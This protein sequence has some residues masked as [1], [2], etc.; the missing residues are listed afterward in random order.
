MTIETSLKPFRSLDAGNLRFTR[1]VAKRARGDFRFVN[2]FPFVAN[3]AG[4][5]ISFN[6]DYLAVDVIPESAGK[7][8]VGQNPDIDMKRLFRRLVECRN[9]SKQYKLGEYVTVRLG[10]V[11]CHPVDETTSHIGVEVLDADPLIRDRYELTRLIREVGGQSMGLPE[12]DHFYLDIAAYD[13]AHP[14]GIDAVVDYAS[15]HAP[16]VTDLF[17]VQMMHPGIRSELARRTA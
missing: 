6:Q 14:E 13:T 1:R 5:N 4:A 15:Q 3:P 10:D 16:Q 17:D 11:I 12:M 9:K 8:I 2:A 7:D